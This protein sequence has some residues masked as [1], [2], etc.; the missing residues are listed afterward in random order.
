M[1]RSELKKKFDELGI[2]ASSYSLYGGN[3]MNIPIIGHKNG[4]WFI[5]EFDERGC[6]QQ[7]SF[8]KEEDIC[9][10][11]YQKV[12]KSYE[13]KSGKYMVESSG[14]KWTYKVTKKGAIIVFEDG[15]P[16]WKNGVEICPENPIILNGKPILFDEDDVFDENEVFHDF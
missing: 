6:Y 7:Y 4:K 10:C 13:F 9:E 3:A 5:Y 1:N 14:K 11:F 2:P 8:D 12:V 15:V 16:K